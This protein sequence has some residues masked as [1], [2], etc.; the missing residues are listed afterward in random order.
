[1]RLPSLRSAAWQ[2]FRFEPQTEEGGKMQN[3]TMTT[4]QVIEA[5]IR[6]AEAAGTSAA[7]I[8]IAVFV[9]E[10]PSA[11]QRFADYLTSEGEA[12]EVPRG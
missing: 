3:T 12:S 7:E 9:E 5:A 2:R 10:D 6:Q 8:L 1:M 4:R 11:I